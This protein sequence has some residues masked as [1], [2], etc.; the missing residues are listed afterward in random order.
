[1]FLTRGCILVATCVVLRQSQDDRTRA[2][3]LKR[4]M[5][6]TAGPGLW[7]LP[8]GKLE[9]AAL[10][11]PQVAADHTQWR[12]VL[13][14][15]RERE[16]REETGIRARPEQFYPLQGGDLIFKRKDGTPCLVTT[17]YLLLCGTPAIRLG[18]GATKYAWVSE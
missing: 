5:D 14:R 18:D 12:W 7:T 17:H 4:R 15:T 16:V 11:E 1:M 6:E 3:I 2:L 13:E 10:G 9:Q 8:G